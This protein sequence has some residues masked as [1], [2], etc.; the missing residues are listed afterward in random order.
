MLSLEKAESFDSVDL[1]DSFAV[2]SESAG[3][4]GKCES[5]SLSKVIDLTLSNPSVSA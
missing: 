5:S 3:S 1:V 4:G 2:K